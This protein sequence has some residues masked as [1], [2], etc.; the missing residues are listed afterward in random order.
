MSPDRQGSPTVL[1]VGL[2][3]V[4]GGLAD[5]AAEDAVRVATEDADRACERVEGGGIDAVLVESTAELAAGSDGGRGRAEGESDGDRAADGGLAVVERLRSRAPGLPVAVVADDEDLPTVA[6]EAYAAGV[7]DC[8]PRSLCASAPGTVLDRVTDHVHQRAAG[9]GGD[10]DR[11]GQPAHGGDVEGE[12]RTGGADRA[13]GGKARASDPDLPGTGERLRLLA[14]RVDEVIYLATDDFAEVLYVNDAYEDVWGRPVE[15]LYDDAT[16]FRE[17]IHPDDRADFEADFEAMLAD[18]ERGEADDVYEFE[19][20]V[21]Q[22]D[23]EVRWVR[24]TGYPVETAAGE[25]RYVG[26]ADDVTER[27]EL[28]RTY[29]EVFDAV[30]D[31]LVVHEPE[32]GEILAVNEEYVEMTG[33]DRERLV[34]A[35][36]DLVTPPAYDYEAARGRIRRA[37]EAGPELF[38]WE[39]SPADGEPYPVEVHLRVVELRGNERVLASIRDITERK[40]REREYEQVFHGVNDAIVVFD[41]D[42]GGIVDVNEA[43]HDLVGYDS[44]EEIRELGI[45][46]LS[47][48]EEGY[49]GERGWELVRAVDESGEPRTVEWHAERN[50]GERRWAEVTLAPAEIGGERRVLSI[51]RDVTDRRERQRELEEEREKYS[52]LVEQSDDG[53]VVAQDGEYVFVNREFTALTGYDEPDLLGTPIEEVM[54]PEYRELVRERY[55]KRVAGEEPPRRYDV[56][57]ETADGEQVD[58]ELTVSRIHHEGEPA[59]LANFRDITGRKRLE[60]QLREREQRLRAIIDRIDE[61]IFLAP[62]EELTEA[63]PAPDYVS[64]GYEAIWG[65]S[66]EEIQATYEDGFFG[67]LHSDDAERY[68]TFL[69]DLLGDVDDGETADRYAIEYRIERPDG[70]QR[71]VH[72]DFYPTDWE[73]GQPRVVIVSRDVTDRRE[74][75]RTLQSFHEATAELTTAETVPDAYR[76]AV[77]AAADVFGLERAAGY[78]YDEAEGV[79][80]PVA[81]TD[82]LAAE[83]ADLDALTVD[84]P[85][86]WRAFVD[87][88]PAHRPV[89]ESPALA[90]AAPDAEEALVL[91]L[92]PH[93]LLVVWGAGDADGQRV[94]AAHILAA[95]LEGA[96]HHIHG[97]RRLES[98]REE[99]A[100]EAERVRRLERL[101]EL[102]RRVEAAITD[103]STRDGIERAVCDR[104]TGIEPFTAAW[105]GEAAVGS[106]RVE[107]RTVQGVARESVGTAL[108]GS[109]DDADPHPA[110]AAWRRG[111]PH[112]VASLV[113]GRT[114]NGWRQHLL[115]DGTQSVC[116]VPLAYG[117]VTHGVLTIRASEPG[118]FGDREREVLGQLGASI[119]YAITAIERR[120]ALESDETLELAF[121]GGSDALPAGRLATEFDC[122]ARHERTTRREDGGLAVYYTVVDAGDADEETV[123]EAAADV[124]PGDVDVVA[125]RDGEAVVERRG[126]SW[127][128]A[129]ITDY[130]GVVRN[131]RATPSG[132]RLVVELP[133]SAE[134]RAFVD[135]LTDAVPDLELTAKRQ[136]RPAETTPQEVRGR[137]EERLT[138]RQYEVLE[139]AYEMG[140]FEWPREHS[141]ED[142][143]DRLDIT[144]PTVNK[145]LRLGEGKL[146]D[147]LFEPEEGGL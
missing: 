139:T 122:R 42:T 77:T 41:P 92:G 5:A 124:L 116:A 146:F 94:E 18:F 76:T 141:G 11:E 73:D 12:A 56:V 110:V 57:V 32:T 133:Q 62:A 144:Q 13:T 8:L 96:L 47:V 2:E 49:T 68:R 34:G 99:L 78:W 72:S 69:L 117:G 33:Y 50:D 125:R 40:R 31:G 64:S 120:R 104:L 90:G 16:S 119:G 82:G 58:V 97:E 46:G 37:Q 118:A 38:E 70:T 114:H 95:T 147:L 85:L 89:D 105:A 51:H 36:V 27:R 23:G 80:A 55:K 106:D 67:T 74:R 20:R 53:V 17:G 59:T 113:S 86:A 145:H 45:E 30:S 142:V 140:Y 131:C 111:E 10:G 103:H 43:Y 71:W 75:E 52:T 60:R 25:R 127:F 84:D 98:S 123:H 39:L 7:A 107:P 79:L 121:E 28:E 29:Q 109:E 108:A 130:G 143:A 102:T 24:A 54:A 66:L 87:D 14:E 81:T 19:F 91:P 6:G 63:D 15:E 4:A 65:Q 128:G 138:D 83:A 112:V 134:T 3:E 115:G 48:T 93:G 61:A 136:H 100:A 101:T 135:R 132:T 137:I 26:I 35:T 126:D 1:V 88:E 129:P 44:L 21:R 9:G 22:P